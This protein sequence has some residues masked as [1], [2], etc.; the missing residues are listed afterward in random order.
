MDG[1]L[2]R[3]QG[4]YDEMV[5]RAMVKDGAHIYD[6]LGLVSEGTKIDFQLQINAYLYGTR[7]MTWLAAP[8]LARAARGVGVAKAGQQG[9]LRVAVQE[10][11]RPVDRG[12]VGASGSPSR[13][14]SSRRTSRRSGSTRSR[15]TRTCRRA[16][17]VRCRAPSTTRRPARS[18]RPSTTPASSRTSGAI[19]AATRVGGG[20]SWTSRARRMFTV[21][22][23]AWDPDGRTL[24]YTSGQR[25]LPRP[26]VAR[27]GDRPEA[28]CCRR[29]RASA[30]SRST[31]P[32]GRSGASGT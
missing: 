1:G 5:F 4:G 27:P 19:D 23:L 6:P 14:R 13:R 21:T 12:R 17:S 16:R 10:G 26:D 30:T 11:V 24:F 7:F 8:L 15:R 28:R 31:A 2:G 22:S 18:T 3:A 29:T 25:R 20:T 32:T 9:L